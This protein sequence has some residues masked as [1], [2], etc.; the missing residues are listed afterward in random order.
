MQKNNK[1]TVIENEKTMFITGVNCNR[2]TA[3]EE[4]KITQEKFGNAQ[5][6]LHN[7][8]TKSFK[9]GEVSPEL[10]HEIGVKLAKKKCGVNI[11]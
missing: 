9:T 11:K 3:L 8:H 10:A 4:M 1:K 2:E 6:I 7:T 5:E